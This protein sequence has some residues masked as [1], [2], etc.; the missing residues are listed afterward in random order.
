MLP[1]EIVVNV[2][3]LGNSGRSDEVVEGPHDLCPLLLRSVE[4]LDLVFGLPRAD[5]RHSVVRIEP[6]SLIELGVVHRSRLLPELLADSYGIGVHAVRQHVVGSVGSDGLRLLNWRTSVGEA[7]VLADVR[8]QQ[9]PA[10]SVKDVPQ[11]LVPAVH[12]HDHFIDV[13]AVASTRS[14]SVH[15][16]GGELRVVANLSIDGRCVQPERVNLRKAVGDLPKAHPSE[17]KVE[18]EGDLLRVGPS[19]VEPAPTGVPLTARL[20]E[21]RRYVV[22]RIPSDTTSTDWHRSQTT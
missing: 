17:V 20:T 7:P 8:R 16:L 13:P 14:L 4:A 15:P 2:E 5:A 6:A 19:V 21:V 12:V 10:L 11:V 9:K 1:D 22:G 3:P 18:G